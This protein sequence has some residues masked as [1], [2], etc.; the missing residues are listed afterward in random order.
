MYDIVRSTNGFAGRVWLALEVG[1][2]L[3][4]GRRGG[5]IAFLK[6]GRLNC[7]CWRFGILSAGGAGIL[8]E[9]GDLHG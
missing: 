8:H 4:V 7:V 1:Y 2:C 3:L 9:V 6:L 5:N